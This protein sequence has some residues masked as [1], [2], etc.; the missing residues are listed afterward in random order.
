MRKM[1]YLD[2]HGDLPKHASG[3]NKGKLDRSAICARYGWSLRELHK[4]YVNW[5]E[6][7]RFPDSTLTF[8]AYLEKLT[9]VGLVPSQVGN[10]PGQYNLARY[11]DM[12]AYHDVSCRFI[13]CTENWAER[14]PVVSKGMTGQ[15]HSVETRRKMSL[16]HQGSRNHNFGKPRSEETRRK[17]SEGKKRASQKHG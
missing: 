10:G 17:I 14:A 5:Y 11:G 2:Y 16:S 3:T 4:A 12:G 9:G 6:I 15:Q 1:S 13:L 8:S 7:F